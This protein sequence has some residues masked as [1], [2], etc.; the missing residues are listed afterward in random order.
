M[1]VSNSP[2]LGPELQ[3][4]WSSGCRDP[5][6]VKLYPAGTPGVP[7]VVADCVKAVVGAYLSSVGHKAPT[8][9]ALDTMYRVHISKF[10]QAALAAGHKSRP[11]CLGCRSARCPSKWWQTVSRQWWEPTCPPWGTK[12]PR[13][14]L[15]PWGLFPQDPPTCPPDPS[16]PPPHPPAS[17]AGQFP[18]ASMTVSSIRCDTSCYGSQ[19][20]AD[21]GFQRFADL[22]GFMG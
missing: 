3:Q 6:S 21:P 13:G 9:V 19:R 1:P 11:L 22:V 2:R 7:K 14:W 17:G 20:F 4:G 5:R 10:N 18:V 12:L 16:H 8:R 15:W